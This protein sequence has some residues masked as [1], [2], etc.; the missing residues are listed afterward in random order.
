MISWLIWFSWHI[1]ILF[2][3]VSTNWSGQCFDQTLRWVRVC[4]NVLTIISCLKVLI[5][6]FNSV[7][8]S[9]TGFWQKCDWNYLYRTLDAW[10]CKVSGLLGIKSHELVP[11]DFVY[12]PT[13]NFHRM[14][15]L[16][17]W[18]LTASYSDPV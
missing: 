16:T 14:T 1:H 2:I 13:V 5:S 15:S 17:A 11:L 7:M 18:S 3:R 9:L 12:T 4:L 10:E 6:S 8:S